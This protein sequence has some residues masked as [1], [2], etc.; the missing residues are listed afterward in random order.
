MSFYE[1]PFD[2]PPHWGHY[3]VRRIRMIVPASD[4]Q[5]FRESSLAKPLRLDAWVRLLG[6][7]E[8]KGIVELPDGSY[9]VH[10]GVPIS[11]EGYSTDF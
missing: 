6:E 3:K 11:E 9:E 7:Y 2:A 10:V 4:V 8:T 1:E 5:L